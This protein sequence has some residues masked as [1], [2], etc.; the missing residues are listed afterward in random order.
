M[1]P[2]LLPDQRAKKAARNFVFRSARRVIEAGRTWVTASQVAAIVGTV[3]VAVVGFVSLPMIYAVGGALLSLFFA[4][5]SAF[6]WRIAREERLR[7]QWARIGVIRLEQR[8]LKAEDALDRTALA[9]AGDRE[10]LAELSRLGNRELVQ[11][12]RARRFTRPSRPR[13]GQPP[14]EPP[15]S[16]R[17]RRRTAAVIEPPAVEPIKRR[18]EARAKELTALEAEAQALA[19]TSDGGARRV[20]AETRAEARAARERVR[21]AERMARERR[22]NGQRATSTPGKEISMGLTIDPSGVRDVR[23]VKRPT[24]EQIADGSADV[25]K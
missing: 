22:R 3:V 4:I 25:E 12:V 8:G 15:E 24:P 17:A 1:E 13:L 5:H 11:A 18:R 23:T 7:R 2:E 21:K 9:L 14:G 10:A 20:A 19:D 6:S 16:P